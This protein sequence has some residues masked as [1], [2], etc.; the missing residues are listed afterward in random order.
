MRAQSGR[1]VV[2]LVLILIGV[3][4]LLDSLQVIRLPFVITGPNL[5][6]TL[7]FGISGLAFLLA[8]FAH[9]SNWWA[10]I[11]GLTLIGL[12]IL[13]GGVLTGKYE[14]LGAAI[15]MGMLAASFWIIYLTHRENWWAIIPGGVLLSV[16][17]LIAADTLIQN[18]LFPVAV[19]FLGMGATF[20][21]LY[22]LPK[23]IGKVTWPLY[24]AGVLGVMGLLF[25]F[26]AGQATN[27]VWA[28]AL[29]A[30]GGW[31]IWR[32]LRRV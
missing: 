8:F 3:A 29:I 12:A 24:P 17:G 11:P 9:T 14:A 10:I 23:P 15:F 18:D 26:G 22:V 7:L 1:I 25:A 21:L 20:L 16:A 2:A 30:G 13:V 32:S 5:L 31:I 27:W 28:I 19:M 4:A 6:W